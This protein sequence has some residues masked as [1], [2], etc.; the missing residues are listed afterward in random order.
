MLSTSTNPRINLK[1]NGV[2]LTAPAPFSPG[3]TLDASMAAFLNRQIATAVA[4]PIPST[5]KSMI[6]EGVAAGKSE[7]ELQLNP[8]ALQRFY[9]ERYAAYT[10]G[11]SNRSAATPADPVAKFARAMALDWVKAKIAAKGAKFAAIQKAKTAD[12][13]S[14][15]EAMI[16]KALELNPQFTELAKMQVEAIGEASDDFDVPDITEDTAG[17]DTTSAEVPAE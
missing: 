12:G 14:V 16:A 4:N 1:V 3:D 2:P 9:D 5:I 10:P 6:A 17:A 13:S 15:L 8:T 7:A 11:A